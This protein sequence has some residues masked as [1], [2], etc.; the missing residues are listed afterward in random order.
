MFISLKSHRSIKYWEGL[1]G[2]L[3]GG[4][5]VQPRFV[6]PLGKLLCEQSATSQCV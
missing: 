1:S 3:Q 4:V 5:Q 6:E 2:I